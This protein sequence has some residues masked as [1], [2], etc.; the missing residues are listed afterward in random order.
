MSPMLFSGCTLQEKGNCEHQWSC[1]LGTL[2][3]IT[4]VLRPSWQASKKTSPDSIEHH[5]N[6]RNIMGGFVKMF[7]WEL[8]GWTGLKQMAR[9]FFLWLAWDHQ[10]MSVLSECSLERLVYKPILNS[11]VVV[12]VNTAWSYSLVWFS[13]GSTLFSLGHQVGR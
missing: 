9:I 2:F 6:N 11:N 1:L 7:L 5:F 12:I 13:Q 10:V 3:V 8:N 4:E